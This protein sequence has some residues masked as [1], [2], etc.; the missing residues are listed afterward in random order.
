VIGGCLKY[1]LNLTHFE[2]YAHDL[3]MVFAAFEQL[4]KKPPLSYSLLAQKQQ[5][6]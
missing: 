1:K 4:E 2:E 5:F 6:K 3:S